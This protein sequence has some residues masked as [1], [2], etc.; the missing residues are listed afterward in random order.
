[1]S[2]QVYTDENLEPS[3][4]SFFE[5]SQFKRTVTRIDNGHKQCDE[6]LAF[7]RERANIEEQYCKMIKAWCAK[8]TKVIEKGSSY[9]T[10][11]HAW[12]GMIK[13]SEKNAE[14]HSE[15]GKKLLSDD[16]EKVKAWK[17]N[18]YHSL[19]LGGLK[20]T[21]VCN[22]EFT[23]AQKP[24]AKLYKKVAENKKL[25]YTACKEEKSAQTQENAAKSD[26]N[27][28]PERVKKLQEAVE[29]KG[30]DRQKHKEKYESA[31][32]D[33]DGYNSR[34]MEDMEQVFTKC[35]D[36]EHERLS[37]FKE[38]LL[39]T[40]GHL[41]IS[42][43]QNLSAIFNDMYRNIDVAKADADLEWWRLNHGPGMPMNWPMF[44]EYDAERI[45]MQ[46]NISKKQSKASKHV[47]GVDGITGAQFTQNS[48]YTSS[49]PSANNGNDMNRPAS[50]SDDDQNNPFD[51]NSNEGVP[52]M[53]LYDYEGAEDDELS[54]KAGDK[55]FKLEEEDEQGWCKG[56]NEHGTV[57]LY[58]ANYMKDI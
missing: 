30:H 51:S 50:W 52:V 42:A 33:L 1:M 21:K 53:A 57:G 40:Q 5:I 27:L 24:W 8:Y 19:T 54:F 15:V 16:F 11:Q 46:R 17:K 25:Y 13:Q 7:I 6:L 35:Q 43:D 44:E 14:L 37:F 31:L 32:H 4:D 38:M 3:T 39:E 29:K 41:N 9:H 23:K 12:L 58:P 48:E 56:R 36:F 55:L 22:D 49:Y 47:A 2:V 45:H 34:Y 28:A 10:L 26:P 20:E 18:H